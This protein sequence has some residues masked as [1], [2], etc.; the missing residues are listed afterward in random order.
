MKHSSRGRWRDVYRDPGTTLRF[1]QV[2]S[3]LLPRSLGSVLEHDGGRAR[4]VTCAWATRRG[5]VRS[6]RG[7][8]RD[9]CRDPDTTPLFAQTSA[10]LLPSS[11]GNAPVHDG[12]RA[13][14]ASGAVRSTQNDLEHGTLSSKHGACRDH[15]TKLRYVPEQGPASLQPRNPDKANFP[16]RAWQEHHSKGSS[17]TNAGARSCVGGVETKD[18]QEAQNAIVQPRLPTWSQQQS[19]LE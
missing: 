14:M 8:W 9:A 17:T 10:D 5:W 3:D 11:L 1:A 19:S 7:R 4:T 6:S 13:R 16:E 2:S 15:G 12:G 18:K